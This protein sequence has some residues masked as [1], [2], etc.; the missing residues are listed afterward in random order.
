MVSS[1]NFP[2]PEHSSDWR[3][4]A[5]AMTSVL[6]KNF[7]NASQAPSIGQ[8]ILYKGAPPQGVLPATGISFDQKLYPILAQQLGSNVTPNVPA[9]AGYTVGVVAG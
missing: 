2:K 9:P 3:E 4:W 8:L 5:Q 7:G 6:Q 1:T